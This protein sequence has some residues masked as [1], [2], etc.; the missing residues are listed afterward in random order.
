M[1]PEEAAS[2]ILES[3]QKIDA[4]DRQLVELLNERTR[5]VESIGQ[6]KQSLDLPVKEPSREDDVFRNILGHNTGPIPGDA[7]KRIFERIIEEMRDLQ[8]MRRQQSG[9]P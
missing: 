7:L 2:Q 4:L 1:T 5:M 8:G 9:K 6:A 3:R